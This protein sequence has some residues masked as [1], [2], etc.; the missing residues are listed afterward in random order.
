MVMLTTVNCTLDIEQIDKY[1]KE[2]HEY[3]FLFTGH[4]LSLLEDALY[5]AKDEEK[6]P[7]EKRAEFSKLFHTMDDEVREFHILGQY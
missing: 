3:G 6:Y 2:P 1:A 4:E 7:E 5:D